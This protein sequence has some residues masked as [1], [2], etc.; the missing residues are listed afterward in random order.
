MS[1]RTRLLVAGLALLVVACGMG[2]HDAGSGNSTTTEEMTTTTRAAGLTT[3]T[4][5][6]TSE[7]T[8][9]DQARI[10]EAAIHDLSRRLLI[11]KEDIEV[12]EARSVQWPDGAIGCP[13]EGQMYTQ[14][15][16]PGWRVLL[17]ANDR[18]YDYH[19]GSDGLIFLCP[20]GD[21]DGGY[22]VVPPLGFNG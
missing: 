12:I 14:A 16:V 9:I 21:E 7:T 4:P 1:V 6:T 11:A 2:S 3:M 8:L 10:T 13:E 17:R 19:A 5:A 15:I 20:S 22:D 18:I